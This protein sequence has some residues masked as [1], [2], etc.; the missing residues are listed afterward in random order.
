MGTLRFFKMRLRMYVFYL[1]FL[2]LLFSSFAVRHVIPQQSTREDPM[3][4]MEWIITA[5][6]REMKDYINS[7]VFDPALTDEHGES[8]LHYAARNQDPEVAK[9]LMEAGVEFEKSEAVGEFT[10]AM[11]A[12][13]NSNEK[14][15]ELFLDKGVSPR[16]TRINIFDHSPG[17][18]TSL[19]MIAAENS[20]PAVTAMLLKRGADIWVRTDLGDRTA[21]MVAAM[22]NPNVEVFK[23]LIQ[24]GLDLNDRD[25]LDDTA[26]TLALGNNPSEAVIDFMLDSGVDLGVTV[27]GKNIVQLARENEHLTDTPTI[28]KIETAY[29]NYLITNPEQVFLK[30]VCYGTF[31][32]VAE[33]LRTGGKRMI[34]EQNDR[35]FKEPCETF[36]MSAVRTQRDPRVIRLLLENGSY[37]SARDQHDW[38]ALHFAAAYSECP[39]IVKLVCNAGEYSL[40]DDTDKGKTALHLAVA[41]PGGAKI[42][43]ALLDTKEFQEG[44]YFFILADVL[45]EVAE[46]AADRD[47]LK[48]LIDWALHHPEHKSDWARVFNSIVSDGSGEYVRFYISNN[49]VFNIKEP[50]E[51]YLNPALHRALENSDPE[52]L[53]LILENGAD[54]N[55]VNSWGQSALLLAVED[56][57]LSALEILLRAGADIVYDVTTS[58]DLLWNVE[59]V[60]ALR[61]LVKYGADLHRLYADGCTLLMSTRNPS[62][63]EEYLRAGID[64]GAVDSYGRTTLD[65][66]EKVHGPGD[67]YWIISE[68]YIECKR[69]LEEA[70]KKKK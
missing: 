20:N 16:Q 1:T 27:E 47:S 4:S 43:K 56:N 8:L 3:K 42:V 55:I 30:T 51:P 5:S 21:L 12:T 52:V 17:K 45:K 23:L 7:P 19:L 58:H 48:L 18:G 15:L 34:S 68:D 33:M 24:A 66:L 65:Y 2:F 10:A 28:R 32:D 61:L 54:P 11:Y 36:L 70:V 6:A 63:M 69:L 26:F 46:Q 38:T 50:A 59:S 40:D 29:Q 35:Y 60:E 39:E 9:L 22:R 67:E 14:M 25:Y 62:V 53:R 41:R 57:N 13:E 37:V 44:S 31:D 49:F 64:P